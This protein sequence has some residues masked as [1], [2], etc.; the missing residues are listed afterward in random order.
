MCCLDF[1]VCLICW[2]RES[3]D[4]QCISGS[5]WVMMAH[6]SNWSCCCCCWDRCSG[7]KKMA[8]MLLKELKWKQCMLGAV[9]E[10]RWVQW[11]VTEFAVPRDSTAT[12]TSAT[13]SPRSPDF[14]TVAT[15]KNSWWKGHR[16][17]QHCQKKSISMSKGSKESKESSIQRYKSLSRWSQLSSPSSHS[18]FKCLL[19][20]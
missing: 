18:F 10:H 3:C 17:E 7:A 1:N 5:A 12:A 20:N 9:R 13:N 15:D 11:R 4:R 16:L 19:K 6:Y 8:W 14:E 2:K